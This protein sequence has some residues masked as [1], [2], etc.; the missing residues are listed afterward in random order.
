MEKGF[1]HCTTNRNTIR[2]PV[3]NIT[4][5]IA[6]Y[7]NGIADMEHI[8]TCL[9]KVPFQFSEHPDT[10]E[11]QLE[12]SR[13]PG[14]FIWV[15]LDPT[16]EKIEDVDLGDINSFK[17]IYDTR[18]GLV[19]LI[20]D[21]DKDPRYWGYN[22]NTFDAITSDK[23]MHPMQYAIDNGDFAPVGPTMVKTWYRGGEYNKHLGIVSS[24][25]TPCGI[26]EYTRQLTKYMNG[27]EWSVLAPYSSDTIAKDGSRV[28]RCF[29]R[30]DL[31]TLKQTIQHLNI[32]NLW[33][34]YSYTWFR[35]DLWADFLEWCNDN[36]IRYHVFAHSTIKDEHSK[37]VGEYS[38]GN[39]STP[40]T[41]IPIAPPDFKV[42]A[43]VKPNTIGTFGFAHP[44]KQFESVYEF[45]KLNKVDYH[46]WTSIGQGPDAKREGLAYIDSLYKLAH[47]FGITRQVHI[48]LGF[49]PESEIMYQL[50]RCQVLVLPYRDIPTENQSAAIATLRATGRPIVTSDASKLK[51]IGDVA[52]DDITAGLSY[53]F[54][55]L[56]ILQ[57][58][59]YTKKFI[60]SKFDEAAK[61]FRV[62]KPFGDIKALWRGDLFG[63][64]SFSIVNRRYMKTMV[65]WG[66][67]VSLL[68]DNNEFNIDEEEY[69]IQNACRHAP[70]ED[71]VS[72]GIHFPPLLSYCSAPIGAW[73]TSKIPETWFPS[74]GPNFKKVIVI[75]NFVKQA[76]ING[77][78]SPEQ[79]DV[80]PLGVDDYCIDYEKSNIHNVSSSIDNKID[81]PFTFLS[82]CWA[83]P[84]KGTDVLID[85][86]TR[87]FRKKDNTLLILK[88]T[89]KNEWLEAAVNH[90]SRKNKSNAQILIIEGV[91]DSLSDIYKCSDVFV[92][93]LRGEGFGLPILEAAAYGIPSIVTKWAGPLDF[94][95]KSTSW[96]VDYRLKDADYQH[97]VPGAKWA[98]PNV[99]HVSSLMK[100]AY[101][102]PDEVKKKGI[103]AFI[104]SLSFSW[105]YSTYL[106]I[107]SIKGI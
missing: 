55:N 91:Q 68:P 75:S 4:S 20:T 30:D 32:D 36:N 104:K 85:A 9:Q 1:C 14:P 2:L 12:I 49:M 52:N 37:L 105:D 24:W 38:S 61:H 93:P 64:Q 3:E 39:V 50:S 5:N 96:Y 44:H 33:I 79:I 72:T 42:E 87:S 31:D 22:V 53:A 97:Y 41:Y 92:H 54:N 107:Q 17:Y 40:Y 16:T 10:K 63:V 35:D 98:E 100:R 48:H 76:F 66:C 13:V 23:Y 106:L 47:E 95:D 26:A 83:E 45:V 18:T 8:E 90:Y 88:T 69:F 82:V 6:V 15:V 58:S 25:N 77:G 80:V 102:R 86:Y 27:F 99:H 11:T 34:H 43:K 89:H 56:S 51:G 65:D 62:V 103:N 46:I 74:I 94:T 78:F 101:N 73:E 70:R 57:P 7:V 71:M 84:R 19:H 67:E 21:S 60:Y 59:A 29:S 81:R 28:F